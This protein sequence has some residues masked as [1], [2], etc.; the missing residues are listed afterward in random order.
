MDSLHQNRL[1]LRRVAFAN[2]SQI[3][4]QFTVAASVIIVVVVT[5]VTSTLVSHSSFL[6]VFT[7]T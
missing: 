4:L 3:T 2:T 1:L 7:P 5:I 6:L